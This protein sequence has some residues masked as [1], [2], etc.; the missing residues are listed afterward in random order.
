MI[1]KIIYAFKYH[2]SP[3][4][5]KSININTSVVGGSDNLQSSTPGKFFFKYPEYF[6]I[7]FHRKEHLFSMAPSVLT[8]FNVDYHPLNTPA[9]SREEGREPTPVQINISLS[10][11]ETEIVTKE[12]IEKGM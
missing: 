3:G 5:A 4:F 10:F 1:R 11:Q 9:Y 7:E 6:E 8:R 2:S 12:S